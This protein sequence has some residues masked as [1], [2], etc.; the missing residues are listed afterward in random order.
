MLKSAARRNTRSCRYWYES[1]CLLKA[2][3]CK[4]LF[5]S[6]LCSNERLAVQVTLFAT[7]SDIARN[8]QGNCDLH[9]ARTGTG[10]LPTE[11][12]QNHV[13]TICALSQTFTTCIRVYLVIF[14]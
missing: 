14:V 5:C 2:P 6:T 13:A 1:A 3:D 7:L 8:A 9:A 4:Q 10:S 12:G 11:Q